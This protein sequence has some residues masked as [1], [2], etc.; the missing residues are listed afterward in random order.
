MQIEN[1]HMHRKDHVQTS[2]T[3]PNR[4]LKAIGWCSNFQQWYFRTQGC[5]CLPNLQ[6]VW[7]VAAT[8][9]RFIWL[10]HPL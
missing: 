8:A 7:R 10:Q 6:R 2:Q 9:Q 3:V 5:D 1:N 4:M